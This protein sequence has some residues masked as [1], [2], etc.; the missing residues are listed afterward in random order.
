M[1]LELD[2]DVPGQD[3]RRVRRR[4][5]ISNLAVHVMQPGLVVPIYVN[6]RDPDDVLIVW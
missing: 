4:L 5:I 2:L 3:R 1:M 6:P